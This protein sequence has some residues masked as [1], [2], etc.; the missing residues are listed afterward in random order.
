MDDLK[1]VEGIGPK[2]E[3]VLHKAGIYTWAQLSQT[4][5]EVL[6][7]TLVAAGPN[8]KILDPTTWPEQGEL[9][10]RGEWQT[11]KDLTDRLTAGRR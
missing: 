8:F 9:L 7:A 4:P 3:D 11:F 1:V 10:A 6:R 5:S 2:V